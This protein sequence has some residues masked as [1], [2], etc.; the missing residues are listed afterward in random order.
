MPRHSHDSS[1]IPDIDRTHDV[2]LSPMLPEGHFIFT[3]LVS[4]DT[5]CQGVPY[6]RTHGCPAF[7][8]DLADMSLSDATPVGIGSAVSSRFRLR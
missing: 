5:I 6:S 3:A 4:C 1:G 2:C 7:N 8:K